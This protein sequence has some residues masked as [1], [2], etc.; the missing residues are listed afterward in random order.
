MKAR[1]DASRHDHVRTACGRDPTVGHL[2]LGD[3][4]HPAPS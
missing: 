1:T 2:S 4:A 3:A